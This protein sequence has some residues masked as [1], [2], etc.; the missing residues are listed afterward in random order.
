[1]QV[2]LWHPHVQNTMMILEERKLP[3]P[4]FPMCGM[5]VPWW[6]LNGTHRHTAQYKKGVEQNIWCLSVEEEKEVTS[7]SFR[8]YRHPL[9][10]V[11]SFKYLDQVISAADDDWMAVLRN[12]AKM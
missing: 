10:M 4:L 12:L 11:T 5:L 9:D 1:M 8:A 6:A 3:H 2:Y 7:R